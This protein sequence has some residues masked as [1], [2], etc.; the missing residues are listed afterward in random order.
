MIEHAIHSDTSHINSIAVNSH[1][2]AWVTGSLSTNGFHIRRAMSP[3][4]PA[5]Q[6]FSSNGAQMMYADIQFVGGS[7][8]SQRRHTG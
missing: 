5:S 2:E 8:F 6:L 4:A 1:G 3:S 7:C